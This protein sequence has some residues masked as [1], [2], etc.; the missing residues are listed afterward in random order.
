MNNR[1][2]SFRTYLI[3]LQRSDASIIAKKRIIYICMSNE[4]SERIQHTSGVMLESLL[5]SDVLLIGGSRVDGEGKVA[6][7]ADGA[8]DVPEG[9]AGGERHWWLEDVEDDLKG[10]FGEQ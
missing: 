5:L 10:Y 8:G 7:A 9:V 4:V 6:A 2:C 3:F 1:R